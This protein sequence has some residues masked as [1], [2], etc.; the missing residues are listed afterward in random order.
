MGLTSGI[1]GLWIESRLA[2]TPFFEE[3]GGLAIVPLERMRTYFPESANPAMQT[4]RAQE[5]QAGC[6]PVREPNACHVDATTTMGINGYLDI[7]SCAREHQD[8][9][10]KGFGPD[11]TR[12][13]DCATTRI[14]TEMNSASWSSTGQQNGTLRVLF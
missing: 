3:S 8:Q 13:R 9:K 1:V 2:R 10:A 4:E 7:T 14:D 12:Q 5:T 6:R 11:G